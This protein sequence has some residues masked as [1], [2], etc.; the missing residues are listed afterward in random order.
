VFKL[1]HYLREARALMIA[2]RATRRRITIFL[3]VILTM[4]LILG[5]AMYLIEGPAHG[6]TSIPKSVY[7]AI[8]TMTTVGYGDIAPK[9]VAG[10]A[11][12]A[13]GMILGYSIIIVPIGVF[14]VGIMSVQHR[15]ASPEVCP[16]CAFE[17]HDE[18]AAHCKRCGTKL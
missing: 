2:L 10:Q 13:V 15:G 5:S 18:D 9:T 1:T 14:S 17:G 8:V 6:F 12:A 3:V 4:L 7:W 16:G 11:L